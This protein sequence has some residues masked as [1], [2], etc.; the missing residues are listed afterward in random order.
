MWRARRAV[1]ASAGAVPAAATAA[2]CLPWGSGSGAPAQS[3][4]PT[5]LRSLLPS[6]LQTRWTTE[7]PVVSSFETT[8]PKYKVDI[9]VAG[10]LWSQEYRDKFQAKV[11]SGESID[12]LFVPSDWAASY[13]K[14]GMFKDLKPLMAKQRVA[15]LK[16]YSPGPLAAATHENKLLALPW[17]VF[18]Q[19]LWYNADL[20]RRAGQPL[21]TPSWG[22]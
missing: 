4:G 19:L 16:D 18:T 14:S 1:V 15:D 21:P 9:E 12:A 6:F 8:F 7:V 22:W 17:A 11:A 2:G 3:A 20:L 13:G 5:T 10:G